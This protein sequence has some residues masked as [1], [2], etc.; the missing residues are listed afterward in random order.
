MSEI[1]QADKKEAGE[2]AKSVYFDHPEMKT[3]QCSREKKIKAAV[4]YLQV[5]T[6]RKAAQ[7]AGIRRQTLMQWVHNTNWWPALIDHLKR[8]HDDQLESRTTAVI[9]QALDQV[10]DRVLNGD[11]VVDSKTGQIHRKP[12]GGRDMAVIFGTL[13]D[14]RQLMRSQPTSISQ[15]SEGDRLQKL[16]EQFEQ[17]AEKK[18]NSLEGEYREISHDIDGEI[19]QGASAEETEEAKEPE[20]TAQ[21]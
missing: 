15:S 8:H 16:Q 7:I 18:A 19:R 3:G 1:T 9:N 17:L 6:F 2:L 5:G 13:Y 14:K 10:E 21:A 20:G 12:V 4:A 11:A